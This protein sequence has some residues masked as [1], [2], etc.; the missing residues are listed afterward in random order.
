MVK[1]TCGATTCFYNKDNKCCK[2]DIMVGGKNACESGD[3]NCESFHKRDRD[4]Y[5]SSIAHPSDNISVDC[6]AVKCVYNSNYR[7]NADKVDIKGCNACTSHETLCATF[8]E[9]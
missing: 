4:T 1:L 6:E 5:T 7:C 9:K 3:T 2:G 8:K